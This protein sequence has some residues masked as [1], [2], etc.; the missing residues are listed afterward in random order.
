MSGFKFDPETHSYTLNGKHLG[1]FTEIFK[2]LGFIDT[3]FYTDEGR[4]RGTAV[5][6]LCQRLDEGYEIDESKIDDA[7]TLGRFQAYKRFLEETGFKPTQIEVPVYDKKLMV[8]CTP[9]RVGVMAESEVIIDLKG[10]A[11]QKWHGYQ[12]AFQSMCLR[13]GAY[14]GIVKRYALY[15]KDNGKYKLE[16]HDDDSDFEVAQAAAIIYRALRKNK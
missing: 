8:A 4:D 3:K 11:K 14:E 2:S 12:T 1:G 5:H 6:L 9:D 10:G 15:L 7:K 16:P 13:N